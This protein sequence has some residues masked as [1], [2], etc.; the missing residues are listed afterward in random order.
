MQAAPKTNSTP[1]YI[2]AKTQQDMSHFV[3]NTRQHLHN[4]DN[5]RFKLT[6]MMMKQNNVPPKIGTNCLNS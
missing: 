6:E 1:Q 3:K 4:I 5:N 2:M